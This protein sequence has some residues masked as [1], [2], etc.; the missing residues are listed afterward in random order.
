MVCLDKLYS[1]E[2]ATLE[3]NSENS[4]EIICDGVKFK[5]QK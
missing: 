5:N 1:L 4:K 3:E 2:A